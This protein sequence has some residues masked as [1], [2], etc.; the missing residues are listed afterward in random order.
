MQKVIEIVKQVA[1]SD[2]TVLIPGKTERK[3]PYCQGDTFPEFKS[4]QAFAEISCPALSQELLE[5]ELSV[6]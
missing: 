3:E 5:S 6:M 1:P 2:S 4:C